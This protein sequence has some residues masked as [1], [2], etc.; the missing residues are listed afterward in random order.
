M[1]CA[2]TKP[3]CGLLGAVLAIPLLAG[4]VGAQQPSMQAG[5]ELPGKAMLQ[6][7]EL[8]EAKEQ[9]T[10]AQRKVISQLLDAARQPPE[11]TVSDRQ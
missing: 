8:L 4:P 1:A 3:F 11:P 2:V 5:G 7:K 10:P 9:R 6:I